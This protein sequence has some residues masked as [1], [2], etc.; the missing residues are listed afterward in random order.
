MN[1]TQK[2]VIAQRELN[3]HYKAHYI[4]TDSMFQSMGKGMIKRITRE[5]WNKIAKLEAKIIKEENQ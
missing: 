5:Y 1:S 4:A 3:K 2:L